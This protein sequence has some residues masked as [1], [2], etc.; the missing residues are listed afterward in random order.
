V[1]SSYG[2]IHAY[3][4]DGDPDAP[5]LTVTFERQVEG[6]FERRE[7]SPVSVAAIKACGADWK[8]TTSRPAG[9]TWRPS[10]S[11]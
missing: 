9:T 3:D 5:A 2:F 8:T 7:L 6:R 11:A 1:R 4:R 10:R